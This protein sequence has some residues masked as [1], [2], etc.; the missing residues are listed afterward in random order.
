MFRLNIQRTTIIEN[1][2]AR[3]V[4]ICTRC[5]RTMHKEARLA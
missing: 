3:K 4:E 2:K 1:G 5:M